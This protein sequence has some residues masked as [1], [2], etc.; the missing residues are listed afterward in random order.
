MVDD[1]GGGDTVINVVG[2]SVIVTGLDYIHY[3]PKPGTIVNATG[4]W[5]PGDSFCD[6]QTEEL[7]GKVIVTDG[8][9][10][11]CIPINSYAYYNHVVHAAALV[12]SVGD[13]IG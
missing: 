12:S 1:E 11:S 10:C 2:D 5:L 8:L 13:A 6:P 9:G 7:K 4:V 3:G